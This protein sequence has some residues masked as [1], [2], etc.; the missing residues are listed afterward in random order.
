MTSSFE[1][2][3]VQSLTYEIQNQDTD[4]TY[5]KAYAPVL[6]ANA[7]R[8]TNITQNMDNI[9]KSGFD[10]KQIAQFRN[11]AKIGQQSKRESVEIQA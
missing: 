4:W 11:L 6:F 5:K 3:K 7:V 8:I 1:I 10:C 9:L 2:S